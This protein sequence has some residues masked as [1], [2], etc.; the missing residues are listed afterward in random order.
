MKSYA[1]LS[2]ALVVQTLVCTTKTF[3]AIPQTKE[4]PR[5]YYVSV[6]GSDGNTGSISAPFQTINIALSHAKPGDQVLV[7]GG[8]YYQEV[9]FPRSGEPGKTISLQAYPGEKPIIDGSR[10]KVSGWLSLVTISNVSYVTIDGFDICNLSSSAVN[11]DPQG[12]AINGKGQHISVKNC[13]IYNIKSHATLEQGRSAHAILV[14]GSSPS[15]I[16]HLLIT[17]CTV[18]DTQTGTSENVTLA[19][20]IEGFIFSHNLVY[21]TENIGVIVAGGDGINPRGAVESNYARNGV[22][23]DNIF[24]HNTMTRTPETWGPDRFGAISIYV[25]GGAN[26][27]IERNIVYESDRGIGLVSESNIYPTRTTTVRNNLVYNC[28]RAGIYM[29]DYLNY[30]IAGTKNCSILNNTLFQNN[31]V[32]G[33]FGEIEGEL[34]LTEHC[35]GNVI[36]YNR[37]YAGPKD[38]LVHKYTL[39]GS[40]NII[41]HNSY[42]SIGQPQWIWNSTNGSPITDFQTWKK[43]SGQDAHSSL[44]I[45]SSKFY[46]NL[47]RKWKKSLP[48]KI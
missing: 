46:S 32:A 26:T 3:A 43:T 25:C 13:H 28:Y 34:R 10:I 4:K 6:D 38:L 40:Q 44:K 14:I 24:H 35:E 5:K 31:R 18:N 12:I 33:A 30:T 45:V 21:D 23:S 17:G 2:L 1:F 37:V 20:N 19:G 41:D 39:T 16:S 42:F 27:L 29:G 11:T 8:T 22:I 7:R 15:P 9:K 36:K 47:S 48:S